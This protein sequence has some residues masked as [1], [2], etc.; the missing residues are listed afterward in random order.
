MSKL[1]TLKETLQ[2]DTFDPLTINTSDIQELSNAMPK[3]GNIDVNNAEVLATKYLRGSDL[4]GELIAMATAHVA[5]TDKEKKKAY[6]VAF[7]IKSQENKNL[8]TDKMRV[9]FAELDDDYLEA[10]DEYN[11]AIAFKTWVDSKYSSFIKAHYMCKTI[12]KRGYDHE[13]A[14]SWNGIIE[15]DTH[16]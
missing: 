11:K 15:D 3:D 13:R 9:A 2:I 12:M 6:N 16:K 5:K 8:K 4:C 7:L 10:C 14:S 1:C